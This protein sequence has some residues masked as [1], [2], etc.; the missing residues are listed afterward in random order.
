MPKV[1]P[2]TVENGHDT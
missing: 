2:K 1:W